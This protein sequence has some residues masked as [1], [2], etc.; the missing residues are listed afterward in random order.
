V[1]PNAGWAQLS[2]SDR[3]CIVKLLNWAKD[4][5]IG[6]RNNPIILL[7]DSPTKLNDN[8]TSSASRVEMIEIML[9]TPEERLAYIEYIDAKLIETKGK[10]LVFGPDYTKQN[11]A[12][13]TADQGFTRCKC[14]PVFPR[15]QCF[16]RLRGIE[17]FW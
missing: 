8:I 16:L 12:H 3:N 7:A 9:P 13:H 4:P 6:R 15:R 11:L 10:G 5:E 14:N 1:F 17:R 2:D